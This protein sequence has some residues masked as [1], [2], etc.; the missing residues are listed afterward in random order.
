[1]AR[2]KA[3][4]WTPCVSFEMR[5]SLGLAL[6]S[7]KEAEI[8][9]IRRW[10]FQG[11]PFDIEITLETQNQEALRTY[12]VVIGAGSHGKPLIKREFC[13]IVYYDNI[14]SSASFETKS[15]KWILLPHIF[16]DAQNDASHIP[17][18]QES[19]ILP[20]LANINGD[21]S[22]L[23]SQIISTSFYAIFPN[24][25]RLPQR[26]NRGSATFGRWTEFSDHF[27]KHQEKQQLSCGSIGSFRKGR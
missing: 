3:H 27:A 23:R 25:L 2:A 21:F 15:G 11:R 19:L 26:Q 9:A 13:S 1:M 24:T 6:P 7:V 22:I 10:S 14:K 8:A 4:F 5:C 16:K 20:I 17:I 12:S 18:D